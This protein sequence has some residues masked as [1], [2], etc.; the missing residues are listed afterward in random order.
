MA[1]A[2][3]HFIVL[4]IT[5]FVVGHRRDFG[6]FEDDVLLLL[7]EVDVALIHRRDPNQAGAIESRRGFH[8]LRHLFRRSGVTPNAQLSRRV[9]GDARPRQQPR[10][11]LGALHQG[12]RAFAQLVVGQAKAGFS[13]SHPPCQTFG[14]GGLLRFERAIS[15]ALG[16][17]LPVNHEDVVARESLELGR[18]LPQGRPVHGLHPPGALAAAAARLSFQR[19]NGRRHT[20]CSNK[21]GCRQQGTPASLLA[22]AFHVIVPVHALH[23]IS[24]TTQRA[25]T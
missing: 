17:Q 9:Y 23:S 5:N 13:V 3:T 16:F 25:F 24:E 4:G 20:A 11:R 15:V 19:R 21:P 7:P 22:F 18:F 1:M 14:F 8:R 12:P 10:A 6:I 2:T